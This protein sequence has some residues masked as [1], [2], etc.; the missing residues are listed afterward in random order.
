[1]R[2]YEISCSIVLQALSQIKSLYKD[3]WDVLI[4]NCD[5]L[6]FLGCQDSTT[7]E[8]ISKSLGKET[9][10]TMSSSRSFGR[11]GGSSVSYNK[12]GRELMTPDELR[13]MDN[14][15]C[16]YFLRG[17]APF[18]A[19]KYDLKSHPNFSRCAAGGGPSYDV[20][21]EKH[22]PNWRQTDDKSTT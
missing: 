21:Q 11:S 5:S 17:L 9:I 7:L 1:M 4:A 22:T 13:T 14:K 3:E 6:L 8:F 16:I 2:K 12:T 10:R 19:R 18:F 15:H 20:A